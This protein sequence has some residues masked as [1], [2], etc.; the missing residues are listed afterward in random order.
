MRA[1]CSSQEAFDPEMQT[2]LTRLVL[3]IRKQINLLD[4]LDTQ[5]C[6][7][8]FYIEVINTLYLKKHDRANK[9]KRWQ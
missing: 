6:T 9:V 2:E 7:D 5:I 4:K 8:L 1:N 3:A